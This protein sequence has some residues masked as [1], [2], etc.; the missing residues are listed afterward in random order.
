MGFVL[1]SLSVFSGSTDLHWAHEAGPCSLLEGGPCLPA[2]NI[3]YQ[4]TVRPVP[5]RSGVVYTPSGSVS[6]QHCISLTQAFPT[7]LREIRPGISVQP[8]TSHHSTAFS[9][10]HGFFPQTRNG[11]LSSLSAVFPSELFPAARSNKTETEATLRSPKAC[12]YM[13]WQVVVQICH[14]T[15]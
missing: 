3:C 12:C 13:I 7:S 1:L 4:A 14:I 15:V 10:Y 2:Q 8:I 9:S 11:F 6:Q 5:L